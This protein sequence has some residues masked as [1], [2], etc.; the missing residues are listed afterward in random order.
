MV[1]F[2]KILDLSHFSIQSIFVPI[3]CICIPEICVVKTWRGEKCYEKAMG[4][5]VRWWAVLKVW[6]YILACLGLDLFVLKEIEAAWDVSLLL[7]ACGRRSIA[8]TVVLQ[9]SSVALW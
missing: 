6:G 9:H 2:G 8:V 1:L 3:L 5:E 4:V 7:M